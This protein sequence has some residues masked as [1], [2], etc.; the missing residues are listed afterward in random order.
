[1]N[2]ATAADVGSHAGS[3]SG[4]APG[5]RLHRT[6]DGHDHSP[7]RCPGASTVADPH[8]HR[9]LVAIGVDDPGA[10]VYLQ[11]QVHLVSQPKDCG[12]P[13]QWYTGHSSSERS[14]GR[15]R[16]LLTVAYRLSPE[17]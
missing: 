8:E 3:G 6:T 14:F 9:D 7:G 15:P 12:H 16:S 17:N 1:M 4:S 10:V 11:G 5:L 13:A 2:A